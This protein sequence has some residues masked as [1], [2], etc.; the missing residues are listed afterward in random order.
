MWELLHMCCKMSKGREMQFQGN[1]KQVN[2]LLLSNKSFKYLNLVIIVPLNHFF[3]KSNSPYVL[4]H[5]SFDVVSGDFNDSVHSTQCFESSMPLV[6]RSTYKQS[7]AQNG[8]WP[9]YSRG[10]TFLTAHKPNAPNF[11]TL[12]KPCY[13]SPLNS[14]IPYFEK[15]SYYTAFWK[16]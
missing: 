2:Y 11:Y 13:Y 6:K 9:M 16:K 7:N 3:T 4:S 5:C 10:M 1:R 15:N 12:K 14:Y 8:R